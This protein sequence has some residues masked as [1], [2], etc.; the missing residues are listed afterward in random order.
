MTKPSRLSIS[1]MMGVVAFIALGVLALREGTEVWAGAVFTVT[2]LLLL[3]AVLHAVHGRG[4]RRATWIGFALFG[5]TY[6]LLSFVPW[7]GTGV[8]SPP[9]PTARLL[10]ELHQRIHN[11]PQFVPNPQFTGLF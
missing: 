8:K 10:E 1:G 2:V 9:L 5:W 4:L 3:G 7:S 6:L 11:A